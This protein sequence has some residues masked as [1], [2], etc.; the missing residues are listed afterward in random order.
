MKAVFQNLCFKSWFTSGAV[1]K[2]YCWCK[3]VFSI[4]GREFSLS[5]GQS[6]TANA[7]QALSCSVCEHRFVSR[8]CCRCCTGKWLTPIPHIIKLTGRMHHLMILTECD[9]HE[10]HLP[11]RCNGFRQIYKCSWLWKALNCKI[12]SNK[13]QISFSVWFGSRCFGCTQLP[14][15]LQHRVRSRGPV[16]GFVSFFHCLQ[17]W[18][19]K[20]KNNP[21]HVTSCTLNTS[22]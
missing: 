18:T 10:A 20:F 3:V 21:S 11:E 17:T 13:R 15:T 19:M 2:L 22:Y 7:L 8:V 4:S 9:F 16:F 6:V 12:S 1:I 5:G 14:V